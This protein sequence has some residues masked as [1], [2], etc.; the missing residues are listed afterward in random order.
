M[1][2][3]NTVFTIENAITK[4]T[5]QSIHVGCYTYVKL[6]IYAFIIIWIL[7]ENKAYTVFELF[8]TYIAE[9]DV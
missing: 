1:D 6:M 5:S 9:G 8:K 2:G 3:R 7:W 4:Y